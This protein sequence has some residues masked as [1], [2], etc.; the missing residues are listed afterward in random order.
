MSLQSSQEDTRTWGGCYG[1]DGSD[2]SVT[3]FYRNV[4]GAIALTGVCFN[5]QGEI[6]SASVEFDDAVNWNTDNTVGSNETDTEGVATHE[7]GHA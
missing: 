5:S 4:T 6:Y 7:M 2:G 1:A 3:I